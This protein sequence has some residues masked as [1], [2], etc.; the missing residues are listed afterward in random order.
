[1]AQVSTGDSTVDTCARVLCIEPATI[2]V[3]EI[4]E[5]HS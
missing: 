2:F 5:G 4:F 3:E 1:M